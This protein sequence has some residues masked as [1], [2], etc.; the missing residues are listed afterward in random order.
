MDAHSSS[1]W[2]P[3]PGKQKEKEKSRERQSQEQQRCLRQ[4]KSQVCGLGTALLRN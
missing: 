4:G 1:Q 3:A 2:L